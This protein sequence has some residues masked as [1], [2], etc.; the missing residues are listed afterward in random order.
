MS[1][2]MKTIMES[3]KKSIKEYTPDHKQR[4]EDF[5]A[6][7]RQKYQNKKDSKF[8]QAVAKAL[9]NKGGKIFP[10][11]EQ[12]REDVLAAVEGGYE[13]VKDF[14]GAMALLN[15]IPTVNIKKPED[16]PEE[17]M[18]VIINL[19]AALSGSM[20]YRFVNAAAIEAQLLARFP[21]Y[22]GAIETAFRKKA[23]LYVPTV[24]AGRLHPV[25]H[26]IYATLA[27]CVVGYTNEFLTWFLGSATGAE[28]PSRFD[29]EAAKAR[30]ADRKKQ[31]AEKKKE[32]E[33]WRKARQKDRE[34]QDAEKMLKD[35]LNDDE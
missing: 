18:F 24:S 28:L 31:A 30:R 6:P 13:E 10:G 17:V 11:T 16:I 15:K 4:K 7:V 25:H 12:G 14:K 32:K 21:Y 29:L 35:L 20:A 19:I 1:N 34:K 3:W 26:A 27:G 33:G 5:L 23:G 8:A 2:E 22:Q 9:G